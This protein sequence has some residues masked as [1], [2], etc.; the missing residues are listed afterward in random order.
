M[1][2]GAIIKQS[3]ERWASFIYTLHWRP[4]YTILAS[5]APERPNGARET[6]VKRSLDLTEG[7][8]RHDA[9]SVS[10]PP[11]PPPA[12][13][14]TPTAQLFSERRVVASRIQTLSNG[15]PSGAAGA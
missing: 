3:N 1:A 14:P 15:S 2:S 11:S 5:I 12:P 4:I 6:P 10:P 7:T 9:V 8:P 13:A